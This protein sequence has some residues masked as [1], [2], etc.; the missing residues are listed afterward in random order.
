MTTGVFPVTTKDGYRPCLLDSS[1]D[2]SLY[3]S[4][5]LDS[6]LLSMD[7]SSRDPPCSH[8]YPSVLKGS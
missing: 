7:R 1:M 2:P 6:S 5:M 3:I 8:L 4:S